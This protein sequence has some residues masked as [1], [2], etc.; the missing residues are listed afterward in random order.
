MAATDQDLARALAPR[1]P[2]G[3]TIVPLD[4][5]GFDVTRDL[6]DATYLGLSS[7]KRR[8]TVL[9]HRIKVDGDRFSME[10]LSREV[11]WEAGVARF[12]GNVS[13]TRGRIIGQWAETVYA[14]GAD[15]SV[16]P[17]VDYTVKLRSEEHTSELQ[18]H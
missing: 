1:L 6:A 3:W 4:D 7:V 10:D 15:G 12:T 2:A 9:T 18:S 17:Q 13:M 5:G 11:R 8:A 16:G 14:V